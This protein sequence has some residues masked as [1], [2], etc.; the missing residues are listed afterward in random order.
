MR[1][2]QFG[3]WIL[4]H[5]NHINRNT[6]QHSI[7]TDHRLFNYEFD[8][9]MVET[10]NEEHILGKRLLSKI[11]YI[12]RKNSFTLQSDTECL[13]YKYALI[14]HRAY[15]RHLYPSPS[16]LLCLCSIFLSF[17]YIK[18][19]NCIILATIIRTF[20]TVVLSIS[21]HSSSLLNFDESPCFYYLIIAFF[22]TSIFL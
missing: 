8:W 16:R 7:I 18:Y 12:I 2:G 11:I 13:K 17:V 4:E 14:N 6:T 22:F 1:R 21:L 10:L 20:L 5:R 15:L 3:L 19:I 9:D